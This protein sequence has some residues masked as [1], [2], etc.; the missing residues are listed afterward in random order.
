MPTVKFVKEN[1]EVE[2]AEGVTIRQAAQQAGINT[3]QGV[4]GIGQSINKFMNCHGMGMCGTCRVNVLAGHG[5]HQ[6]R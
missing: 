4:N 5:E 3:N 2:V 1:K 6:R